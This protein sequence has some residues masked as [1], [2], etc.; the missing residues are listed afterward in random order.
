MMM[1]SLI[2]NLF[3]AHILGDFY[4]QGKESCDR[5]ILNGIRGWDLWLHAF[6]IGAL[7]WAAVG[8][9][10]GWWLALG[11]FVSHLLIDWMKSSLQIRMKIVRIEEQEGEKRVVA[12]K[13][14]QC[15]LWMFLADQVLHLLVLVV[16]ASI[17]ISC[18]KDWSQFGW[19]QNLAVSHPVRV[20]TV[21][22]LLLALK[23]ANLLVLLTLDACKVKM[24]TENANDGHGNFHSGELI[25]WLER[26]LI[27]LFVV[28]A[29]YE[30]IGFL[31]AAKSILRFGEASKDEKSE[32]VLTGTLLSL[33]IA[34]CL[35]LA[36]L[37]F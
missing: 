21:A 14:K 17:W 27:L 23:P 6:L 13:K 24:G 28:L 34:V 12:G 15:D 16:G 32:Y 20:K 35:G 33:A 37:A 19:L 8:D 25:G 31:V 5:K 18:N 36:V 2:F 10:R 30:A 7:S 1:Q 11:I 29:Q 4:L 3:M 22:A 9:C 26:G